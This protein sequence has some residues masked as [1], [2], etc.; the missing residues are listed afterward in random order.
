MPPENICWLFRGLSEL[1]IEGALYNQLGVRS[2]ECRG[3]QPGSEGAEE[4]D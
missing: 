1:I 4:S 2:L 3:G